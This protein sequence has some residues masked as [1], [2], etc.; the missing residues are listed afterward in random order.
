MHGRAMDTFWGGNSSLG[1]RGSAQ[2]SK[3]HDN[4]LVSTPFAVQSQ[5]GATQQ[6]WCIQQETID[7]ILRLLHPTTDKETLVSNEMTLWEQ[8]DKIGAK[9]TRTELFHNVS[10]PA[11]NATY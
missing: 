5:E 9:G 10:V 4:S 6:V 7:I 8:Y 3:S 11:F 2:V 1:V